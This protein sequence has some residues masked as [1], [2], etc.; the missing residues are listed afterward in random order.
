MRRC[1]ALL[2][3]VCAAGCSFD[4]S[5]SDG[6]PQSS[7]PTTT[8]G[9]GDGDGDGDCPDAVVARMT[10]NGVP[11][12]LDGDGGC[13]SSVDGDAYTHLM[14]GD[15]MSLSA[16]GSC[17]QSGSLSVRW[18]LSPPDATQ[19]TLV[20]GTDAFDVT[21]FSARAD[22]EYIVTL[23]ASDAA[24]NS[25][26]CTAFAYRTVGFTQLPGGDVG[27]EVR[28]VAVGADGLWIAAPTGAFRALLADL[29]DVIAG[30]RS[31][32]VYETVD[33]LFGGANPGLEMGA[34]HFEPGPAPRVWFGAHDQRGDVWSVRLP[35]G[36]VTARAFDTDDAL[37]GTASVFDIGA[38]P[39][40]GVELATEL[41]VTVAADSEEFVGALVP[42]DVKVQAVA[43][44]ELVNWGGGK[45]LW[46]LAQPSID[47]DLLNNGDNKILS[48]AVDGRGT[49]WVG[50][51]GFGVLAVD[52]ATGE[53]LA[54]YTEADGLASNSARAIVVEQTG[55]SAGDVW[56]AGDTGISR[57][58]ADRQQWVELSVGAGLGTRVDLQGLAI[59]DQRGVFTLFGGGGQGLVYSRRP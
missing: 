54:A 41:G 1:V 22:R 19:T 34:A 33:R 55:A 40:G 18:Q 16:D 44:A 59:D 11:V 51:D 39:A 31:R 27:N 29:D 12:A 13:V 47:I 42:E 25:A 24:G 49:L 4:Q 50:T 20:P 30:D 8:A 53:V 38:G 35:N 48:L 26:A 52:A 28:D 58:K 7:G 23:T 10:I 43:A 2:A 3:C 14:V 32:D 37:G 57:F 15:T 56:V 46:N 17:A 9:D 45:F 5:A 6:A 21:A 36:P